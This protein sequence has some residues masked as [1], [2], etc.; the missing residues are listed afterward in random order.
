MKPIFSKIAGAMA[1]A[2]GVA[3]QCASA[4]AD[5][6]GPPMGGG[7][8]MHDEGRGPGPGWHEKCEGDAEKCRA[9]M[10]ARMEERFK[11]WF[12]KA[13]HDGNGSLSKTEAEQGMPML[14]RNF[15]EIDANKDGQVTLEEFEAY[16]KKKMDEFAKKREECKADPDKCHAEMLDRMK[17]AFKKADT[18]GDGILTM[19]EAEKGAPM[20]AHQFYELDANKD[21]KVSLKEFTD[22]HDKQYAEARKK[23]AAALAHLEMQFKKADAN[24]DGMLSMAEAEKGMPDLAKCFAD[25]DANDDGMISLDEAKATVPMHPGMDHRRGHDGM[26]MKGQHGHHGGM[27]DGGGPMPP[28]PP[29]D[30]GAMPQ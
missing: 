6:G 21:G 3:L 26:M 28:H 18:N 20:I 7:M 14:A 17:E 15:D 25:L 29:M 2:A 11:E 27:M 13:D 30:D 24:H 8:M 16:N 22:F 1:L 10:Q 9:E 23:R 5:E 4:A 19:M 12:K